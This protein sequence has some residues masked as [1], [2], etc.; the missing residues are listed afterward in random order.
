M[1][2]SKQK[3]KRIELEIAHWLQEHGLPSA[4]RTQQFNG[5]GLGSLSDIVAPDDLPTWHIEC[6]GMQS[7]CLNRSTLTK[8]VEQIKRDCPEALQ[9]VILNKANGKPIIAILPYNVYQH[10]KS[11]VTAREKIVIEDSFYPATYLDELYTSLKIAIAVGM[12]PPQEVIPA[13]YYMVEE[14]ILV[15]MLAE[16]WLKMIRRA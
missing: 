13:L 14:Y 6:K 2:N 11:G 12:E 16:D 5:K 8:W 7:P 15:F 10:Y 1:V 9:P 4:R 3:G